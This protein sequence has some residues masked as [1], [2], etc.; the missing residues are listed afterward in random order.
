VPGG[1]TI[2]FV[3]PRG[4]TYHPHPVIREEGGTPDIVGSIRAGL[5]FALKQ[6][7]GAEEIR[8]REQDFARRALR[9]WGANRKIEILGNTSVERLPIVTFGLRHPPRLLHSAFV[10]ALLS[11]LFGIQ[12]RSG[13]FCAGPYIHRMYSI[14]DDWSAQMHAECSAGHLGVKLAFA[15]VGFNYFISEAVFEYIL[16]AVHLLAEHAWKLLPLYRFDTATGLWQH[17]EIRSPPTLADAPVPLTSREP[18]HAL[19]ERLEDARR[20]VSAVEVCPP[21]E[22]EAEPELSARFERIRWFPLPCE[23]VERLAPA[24]RG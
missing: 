15:R 11:D 5:A 20:I 23:A 8:R 7:V 19:A 17:R 10:V 14:D 13:C 2:L 16:E 24:G 18:V 1:G 12:A 9:S 21:E 4:H 3:S 22:D 6:R